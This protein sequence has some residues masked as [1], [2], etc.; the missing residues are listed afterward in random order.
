V[1]SGPEVVAK[2]SRSQDLR[3]Y[4]AVGHLRSV[5]PMALPNLGRRDAG[6]FERAPGDPLLRCSHLSRSF[7]DRSAV[8]D[9]SLRSPAARRTGLL[10][11][12]GAG[13]TT[14]IRMVCGLLRKDAGEVTLAGA[15]IDETTQCTSSRDVSP[16]RAGHGVVWSGAVRAR[17]G[18]SRPIT[19]TMRSS[20]KKASQQITVGRKWMPRLR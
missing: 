19:G 8:D 16:I 15:R 9:V 1:P 13:K 12:N 20:G 14:T 3:R 2:G 10:G 17:R 18:S 6:E 11:P 4:A 5:E 7:G